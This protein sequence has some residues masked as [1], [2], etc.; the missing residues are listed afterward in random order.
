MND[1][2]D[3][4]FKEQL[5]FNELELSLYKSFN[6]EKILLHNPFIL[7]LTVY[8]DDDTKIFYD[9]PYKTS[10][11]KI[12]TNILQDIVEVNIYGKDVI[13]ILINND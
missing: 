5:S 12:E 6:G 10:N 1:S 11:D 9:V 13:R 8:L 7:S 3:K 2:E 4:D